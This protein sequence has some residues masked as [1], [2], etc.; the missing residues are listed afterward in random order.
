MD[1]LGNVNRLSPDQEND[2]AEYAFP[3]LANE[4]EQR[5]L[6]DE[7]MEGRQDISRLRGDI[8]ELQTRAEIQH[9]EHKYLLKM[10]E[11]NGCLHQKNPRLGS[12]ALVDQRRT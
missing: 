5:S 8:S 7:L 11:R 6:S 1:M 4:R 2:W 12:A 10:L 3:Q 9:R